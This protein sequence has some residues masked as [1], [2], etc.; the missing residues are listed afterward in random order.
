[1][2]NHSPDEELLGN[3]VN[4]ESIEVRILLPLAAA[5]NFDPSAD[6]ATA[7]QL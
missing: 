1:M 5:T 7:R 4:P 3:Q 6:D 2:A